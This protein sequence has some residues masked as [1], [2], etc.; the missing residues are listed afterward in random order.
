MTEPNAGWSTTPSPPP[1]RAAGVTISLLPGQVVSLAGG[2]LVMVGAWLDWVRP[3]RDFGPPFGLSAYDVP[4]RFLF[5]DSGFAVN[6]GGPTIGWLVA[7]VG[8]VCIVAALTRVI[9][10]LALPAGVAALALAVWYA[11]R[12][13]NLVDNFGGFGPSFGDALG[14]GVIVVGLGGIVA[15][16]G[17]ILSLAARPPSAVRTDGR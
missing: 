9:A 12:L 17:G 8:V 7:I 3:D 13:R 6:R 5:R 2:V 4:A 15:A 10:M 16:I 11:L 14:L 1:T